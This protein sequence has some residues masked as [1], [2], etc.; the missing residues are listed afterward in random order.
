MTKKIDDILLAGQ[1][2]SEGIMRNKS[3]PQKVGLFI[4]RTLKH[5]IPV[6]MELDKRGVDLDS[7]LC[8]LCND[9]TESVDHAIFLCKHAAEV[10]S[11]VF[12]WWG[13]I[14]SGNASLSYLFSEDG[15]SSKSKLQKLTW[16]AVRWVTGYHIWKNRN[17]K[18]FHKDSWATPKIVSEIQLKT[19]EWIS[20]RLKTTSFDW[21]RWLLDPNTVF[22]LG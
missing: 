22:D 1:G 7:V 6:R 12:N 11:R 21:H 5:R 17:H 2:F 20:S 14:L 4:W 8:P 15:N 13:S 18:V 3:I 19:F 16:Q 9:H 10:W